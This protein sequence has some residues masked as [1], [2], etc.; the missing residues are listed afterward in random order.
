MGEL[1]FFGFPTPFERV[2]PGDKFKRFPLAASSPAALAQKSWVDAA[3]SGRLWSGHQRVQQDGRTIH[4]RIVVF[5]LNNF[6]IV[7][8]QNQWKVESAAQKMIKIGTPLIGVG[9]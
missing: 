8:M 3:S 9:W 5:R 4:W 2:S 1:L 6:W 7:A